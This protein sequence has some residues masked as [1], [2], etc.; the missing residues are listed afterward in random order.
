MAGGFGLAL[1]LTVLGMNLV[2]GL[3]PTKARRAA[4]PS[5]STTSTGK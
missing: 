3:M 2:L 1:G 5:S 4:E